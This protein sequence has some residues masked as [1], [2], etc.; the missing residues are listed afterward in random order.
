MMARGDQVRLPHGRGVGLVL[1]CHD[2]VAHVFIGRQQIVGAPA[3]KTV[4]MVD[5]YA[6]CELVY[7]GKHF[8]KPARDVVEE[9]KDIAA[10]NHRPVL[11]IVSGS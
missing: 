8:S 4:P 2:G 9:L 1:D 7:T 10:A 6:E 11:A 3:G 5:E